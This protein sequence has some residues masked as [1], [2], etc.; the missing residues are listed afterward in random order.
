MKRFLAASSLLALAACSG[1]V[2]PSPTPP[3]MDN[4]A[5]CASAL[6]SAGTSSTFVLLQTALRTPACQALAAD[7]LQQLIGRVSM[8]Q[9]ARGVR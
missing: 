5:L 6:F 9:H 1:T 7:A 3:P 8:Q 4:L 2:A